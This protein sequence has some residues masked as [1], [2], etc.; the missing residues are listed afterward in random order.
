MEHKLSLKASKRCIAH[1]LQEAL[2]DK[3]EANII[4]HNV[5]K[6][7]EGMVAW[8]RRT[9]DA[10]IFSL[11]RHR[12]QDAKKKALYLKDSDAQALWKHLN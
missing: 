10:S 1:F 8:A 9:S 4:L 3:K 12:L 6:H 2:K 7:P 11:L 5:A